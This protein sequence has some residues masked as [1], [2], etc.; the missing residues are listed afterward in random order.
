MRRSKR[1]GKDSRA[2]LHAERGR[3]LDWIDV[4]HSSYAL[5]RS[6]RRHFSPRG[7]EKRG[8]HDSGDVSEENDDAAAGPVASLHGCP[9][10]PELASESERPI[11]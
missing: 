4:E 9:S 11:M 1:G 8:P 3:G 6:S 2:H 7:G 5:R 10:T